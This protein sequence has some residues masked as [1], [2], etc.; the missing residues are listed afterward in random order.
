MPTRCIASKSAVM[1]SR[2][3]FPFNQNQYTQGRALSG[4]DK[5]PLSSFE[6]AESAAPA[7]GAPH[8]HTAA[9]PTAKK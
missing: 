9:M 7:V 5:K 4:G 2:V 1:P 6:A 3:M 8:A